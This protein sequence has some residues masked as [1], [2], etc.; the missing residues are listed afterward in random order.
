MTDIRKKGEFGVALR[1]YQPS[2]NRAVK[3]IQDLHE[4][5]KVG[6]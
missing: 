1:E 2:K 5:E 4:L 6:Y 3:L